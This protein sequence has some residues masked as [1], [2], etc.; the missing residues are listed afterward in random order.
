MN[1]THL[2]AR[3]DRHTP[4]SSTISSVLNQPPFDPAPDLEGTANNF[5][6]P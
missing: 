4:G 3:V 6:E 5:Q 1:G 2:A